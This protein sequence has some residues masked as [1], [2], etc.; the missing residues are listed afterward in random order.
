MGEEIYH[1]NRVGAPRVHRRLTN[2]G[3]F[4]FPEPNLLVSPNKRRP[5]DNPWIRQETIR[6]KMELEH[7]SKVIHP[8]W[9][10][11]IKE[12]T[13][14]QIRIVAENGLRVL[15]PLIDL[16]LL[17]PCHPHPGAQAIPLHDSSIA[18]GFRGE[19]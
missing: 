5:D 12:N 1:L 14:L 10:Y 3:W 8:D 15:S 18:L 13:S 7:G 19:G 17:A 6:M 11:Q 16:L 2:K 9:S 4:H